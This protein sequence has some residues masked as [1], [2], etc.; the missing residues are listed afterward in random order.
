[1]K[2]IIP[3]LIASLSFS[4][5]AFSQQIN[6]AEQVIPASGA[7]DS[8]PVAPIP[9]STVASAPTITGV[10]K[11][12]VVNAFQTKVKLAHVSDEDTEQFKNL[13]LQNHPEEKLTFNQFFV[14]VDRNPKK[15]NAA[16][17]Y[18]NNDEKTVEIEGFTKVSTG[19]A[20]RKEHFYTPTGWFENLPENGSYRAQ[21]TKNQNGIRGLGRKGMRVW[22]FGWQP[23]QSGWKKSLH[24]DIRFE[25]HATDPD[26]LEQR[27]GRPDSEGCV[28][29]HNTFNTFM[30]TYGVIDKNYEDASS[31]VLRKDRTPAANAG[32]WL[33]VFDSK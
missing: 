10:S 29:V 5:M 6:N 16:L 22:D 18:W 1:M 21:G 28:R 17:V 14:A 3:V 8:A 30:D 32:S 4:T 2:K 11:E 23:A 13:V 15:Q 25:M 27:L 12:D 26:Y 9:A 31:W 33:L 7:I 19:S 24:I 20:G